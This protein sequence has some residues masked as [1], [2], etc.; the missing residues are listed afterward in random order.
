MKLYTSK[1]GISS[2]DWKQSLQTLKPETPPPP[3]VNMNILETT[4][5]TVTINWGISVPSNNIASWSV[6]RIGPINGQKPYQVQEFE[7]GNESKTQRLTGFKPGEEYQIRIGSV[8]FN[9]LKSSVLTGSVFTIPPTPNSMNFKNGQLSWECKAGSVDMF[10]LSLYK[11]RKHVSTEM[12]SVSQLS[13]TGDKY[14]YNIPNLFP[15][16]NYHAQLVATITKPNI[17]SQ[18]APL[19]FRTVPIPVSMLSTTEIGTDYIT[20]AWTPQPGADKYEIVYT[21]QRGRSTRAEET[22]EHTKR[23]FGLEASTEY[24]FEIRVVDKEGL[25]SRPLIK[26]FATSLPPPTRVTFKSITDTAVQVTWGTSGVWVDNYKVCLV[27]IKS[28]LTIIFR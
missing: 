22:S 25:K 24:K 26:T 16:T 15:S 18:M 27:L 6:T 28:Q 13:K 4:L 10:N 14:I 21:N 17:K 1:D 11:D 2:K 19:T 9:G 20:L 3:P 8:G 5:D 12:L 7:F 23:I